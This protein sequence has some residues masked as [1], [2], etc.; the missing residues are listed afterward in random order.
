MC[1]IVY[2]QGLNAHNRIEHCIR[3]LAHRGPDDEFIVYGNESALA[4]CRLSINDHSINGRQPFQYGNMFAAINGEIYNYKELAQKFS[5]PLKGCCDTEILLPLYEKMGDECIDEL[6]GF[7]SAVI[8]HKNTL[9]CLR[10]EMGQKPLFYG[11]TKTDYFIS[12]ELKAIQDIV[13][14]EE[15]P[16]GLTTIAKKDFSITDH[17]DIKKKCATKDIMHALNDAVKKRIPFDGSN[18]G[19]FLSGG[20]DSSIIAAMATKYR[21]DIHFFSL[22]EEKSPDFNAIMDVVSYLN[23]K[24]IHFVNLPKNS[25]LDAL[26]NKIVYHTE[27]F[28]PSII[29]N[30]LATY[31]LAKNARNLGLKVVLS[32]EGSDELF[33]GY[34]YFKQN[35]DWCSFRNMLLKDMHFTELRRIDMCCMANS[36]ESRCPFLDREVLAI[37]NN[38]DYENFFRDGNG[39]SILRDA[40][41]NLLP[42]QIVDRKKVSCDVGSGIRGIVVNY[43]KQNGLTERENLKQIWSRYN[44]GPEDHP[45]FSR[46]PAFDEFIDK[47]GDSHCSAISQP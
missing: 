23:I 27:S 30:G 17:Q 24:N 18:F 41:V 15:V 13:W 9:T 36:I 10:D 39:K 42:R 46:Y 6:D 34:R 44:L 12:S 4:F 47:R 32:G 43:L 19:I 45:Y 14:F 33:G 25:E 38:L 11:K 2:L 22:A 29:S 21:D 31:L 40:F 28:N 3:K 8:V 26:I 5:I 1:G 35:E 7:Y 16:I 20:L 37:S